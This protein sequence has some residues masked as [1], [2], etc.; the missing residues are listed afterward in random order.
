MNI[1]VYCI[2]MY[3]VAVTFHLVI[4]TVDIYSHV[5]SIDV[6]FVLNQHVQL[7]K[8]NMN[9]IVG[10]SISY[11]L[12]WHMPLPNDSLQDVERQNARTIVLATDRMDGSVLGAL[13]DHGCWDSWYPALVSCL[14]SE[15]CKSHFCFSRFFLQ[16]ELQ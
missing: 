5:P 7:Q 14:H 15:G 4:A 10:E 11:C 3:I 13:W 9:H 8:Y 6:I 16:W 12:V 2:Y 1:Y